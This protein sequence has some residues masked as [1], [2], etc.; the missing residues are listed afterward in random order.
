VKGYLPA[1]QDRREGILERKRRDYMESIPQ[2][3][4]AEEEQTPGEQAIWRQIHVDIL[5]THQ[6]V[7]LFQQEAVQKVFIIIIY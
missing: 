4:K 1:K 7:A 3:Y 5:R 2:Y 6:S